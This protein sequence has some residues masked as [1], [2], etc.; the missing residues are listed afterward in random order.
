MVIVAI[1][2]QLVWL[3]D[4]FLGTTSYLMRFSLPSE[5]QLLI[6]HALPV[7]DD[8]SGRKLGS[9]DEVF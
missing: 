4:N 9:Q 7:M 8:R 5:K 1:F 6:W 3:R 2:Q